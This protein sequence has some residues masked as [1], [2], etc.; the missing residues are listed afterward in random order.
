LKAIIQGMKPLKEKPWSGPMGDTWFVEGG[1]TDGSVFSRGCKSIEKARSLHATLS[2][3]IGQQEEY[4]VVPK[5]DR[6]GVKQWSLKGWPGMPQQQGPF[7]AARAAGGGYQPRFR[8]SEAGFHEEGRRIARSVALQ[9]AVVL[10]SGKWGSE[11]DSARDVLCVAEDFYNWLVKIIPADRA[12]SEAPVGPQRAAPASV[13]QIEA[14]TK[15]VQRELEP[16]PPKPAPAKG[17]Y[18]NPACPNCGAKDAVRWSKD[19]GEYYCWKKL[20]T[21]LFDLAGNTKKGCG[22]TW[23]KDEAE[24]T[25]LDKYMHEIE[26]AV[27]NKDAN[28]LKKL[29]HMALGSL[30]EQR[31]TLD[32]ASTIDTRLQKAKKALSSAE[33]L[34]SWH[35]EAIQRAKASQPEF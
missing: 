33:E 7:A 1:F 6:D 14:Q 26:L 15:Q 12:P 18:E 25:P 23:K 20:D 28:R 29:E 16:E 17:S 27:Q 35:Q 10:Y 9:E 31:I 5:A 34:A 22:H 3:L 24:Q 13:P 8:D 32:E 4:E 2:G 11:A 30:D 21:E 19:K